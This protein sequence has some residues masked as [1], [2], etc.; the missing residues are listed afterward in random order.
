M[1]KL[2]EKRIL[3]AKTVFSSLG[4]IFSRSQFGGYSIAADGVIFAL[5]S[6]G[7][8]YL[9][10]A[11]HNEAFFSRRASAKTHL[12]QTWFAGTAQLLFGCGGALAG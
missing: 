2:C 8:L 6:G 3:Q 5:V 1:K 9:R 11:R 7:E 12:Y 4:T 10:A